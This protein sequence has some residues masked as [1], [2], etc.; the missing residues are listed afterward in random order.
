MGLYCICLGLFGFY[1]IFKYKSED[2]LSVQ[3]RL[4]LMPIHV[5]FSPDPPNTLISI[6]HYSHPHTEKLIT[7]K[8]RAHLRFCTEFQDALCALYLSHF[9]ENDPNVHFS[10]QNCKLWFIWQHCSWN[11]LIFLQLLI[12]LCHLTWPACGHTVTKFLPFAWPFNVSGSDVERNEE[13]DPPGDES[14]YF[15]S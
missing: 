12:S 8:S 5:Y 2:R 14:V 15:L 7:F 4:F 6:L 9:P 3:H 11:G 13:S 10:N 1:F